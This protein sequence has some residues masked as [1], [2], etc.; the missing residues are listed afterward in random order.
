MRISRCEIRFDHASARRS[1]AWETSSRTC[2]GPGVGRGRCGRRATRV[3][4]GTGP[5]ARRTHRRRPVP[6]FP[7]GHGSFPSNPRC[8]PLDTRATA[9]HTLRLACGRAGPPSECA[10]PSASSPAVCS[11][12]VKPGQFGSR[13]IRSFKLRPLTGKVEI[14]VESLNRWRYAANTV[15]CWITHRD[16]DT[17]FDGNEKSR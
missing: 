15:G 17:E 16:R 13:A 8:L 2:A 12:L 4:T 7:G 11:L 3:L 9:L 5:D 6:A 1:T 14:Q 10:A